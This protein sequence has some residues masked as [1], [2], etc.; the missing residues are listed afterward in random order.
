[1]LLQN[2][3]ISFVPTS[4]DKVIRKGVAK[5]VQAK[6]NEWVRLRPREHLR[7]WTAT[8]VG[9]CLRKKWLEKSGVR[10]PLEPF[11][12]RGIQGGIHTSHRLTH[13]ENLYGGHFPCQQPQKVSPK[14][15]PKNLLTK[16]LQ[17]FFLGITRWTIKNSWNYFPKWS[18]L[19]PFNLWC[20]APLE[21]P[22]H[23]EA[24]SHRSPAWRSMGQ[25]RA[26]GSS[27]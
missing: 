26:S 18:P 16:D 19:L 17:T 11:P 6:I 24:P 23:E 20:W 2:A 14:I 10:L 9:F 8:H 25:R 3:A 5:N 4:L 7:T 27:C 15:Q 1:M 12:G 13:Q 21:N 22:V